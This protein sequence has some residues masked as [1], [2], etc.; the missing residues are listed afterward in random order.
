MSRK[1]LFLTLTLLFC[2]L[3]TVCSSTFTFSASDVFSIRLK[4]DREGVLSISKLKIKLSSSSFEADTT[5]LTAKIPFASFYVRYRGGG[6]AVL[7]LDTL[8]VGFDFEAA[9]PKD[10]LDQGWTYDR[11]SVSDRHGRFDILVQACHNLSRME[12]ESSIHVDSSFGVYADTRTLLDIRKYGIHLYAE[13]RFSE[14]QKTELGLEFGTIFGARL[15]AS[16]G[17]APVYG[18]TSRKHSTD[19][20]IWFKAGSITT[21]AVNTYKIKGDT[22]TENYTDFSVKLESDVMD[23]KTST[24]LSRTSGSPYVFSTP[25]ISLT[26]KISRKTEIGI[27]SVQIHEDRSV[28]IS[29]VSEVSHIGTGKLRFTGDIDP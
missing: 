3:G 17:E 22:G 2:A 11:R 15:K 12:L 23:L 20:E 18:Q 13:R 10:P 21:K 7:D 8:K 24:R 5:K 14:D 6:G 25:Q 4:L 9:Q 29:L 28:R 1:Q 19:Y 16:T 27:L 26:L